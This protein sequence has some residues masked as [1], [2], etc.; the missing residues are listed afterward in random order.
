MPLKLT[1]SGKPCTDT[2]MVSRPNFPLLLN[3]LCYIQVDSKELGVLILQT[4][5]KSA[6]PHTRHTQKLKVQ[7][8]ARNMIEQVLPRETQRESTMLTEVL[9]LEVQLFII[10]EFLLAGKQSG[11]A[12]F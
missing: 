6:H 7:V 5:K 1:E 2:E 3:D 12:T 4:R 9:A 10:L 11:V 8:D